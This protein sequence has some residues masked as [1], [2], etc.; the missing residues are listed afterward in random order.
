MADEAI[1]EYR[2][3]IALEPKDAEAHSNLAAEL[4]LKGRLDE[5]IAELRTAVGLQPDYAE[6]HCNLGLVLH[7][8]GD[9]AEALP[10]LKH[11]HELGAKR[12]D[13]HC[14]SA[15]WV[16]QCEQ[17]LALDKKLPAIL[18]GETE[19]IDN[20]ERLQLVYLCYYKKR[21]VAAVG[22]F[23]DA[24]AAEPKLADDPNASPCSEAARSAALV[25]A[26]KGEDGAKL[27]DKVRA[28]LR[29][30]ALTWLRADSIAWS[31][32]LGKERDKARE[33][34]LKTMHHWQQDADLANVRGDPLANLPEAEQK[35]W[36]KFWG[37]VEALLKRA[38]EEQ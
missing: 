35:E 3:A 16:Q 31:K 20:Q 17:L 34:V 28:R 38:K 29:Q 37:D 36:L 23:T 13:W 11:G 15:Q 10:A 22:F 18:K 9:F 32:L 33:T 5:A 6:A 2:K 25:A 26:G 7:L 1:A 27:D 19:P 30:Q 12:K 24:F 14:P 8:R 4:V 21:Y